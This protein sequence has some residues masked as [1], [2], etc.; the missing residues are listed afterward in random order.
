MPRVIASLDHPRDVGRGLRRPECV[1]CGRDGTLYVSDWR[2]GVTAIAADGGQ[3]TCLAIGAPELRPNGIAIDRD[4]S[5]LLADLGTRGGVW[6]LERDG[7]LSPFCTEVDG[8][9]VPPANFVTRDRAGRAWITVSTRRVP[10]ALGYRHDVADGFI[11]RVTDRGAAI[12]ADGLGYTNE[13]AVDPGGDWLYVNETFARRLSRF[14]IASGGD[15]GP[16]E[17]VAR[18]GPGTFPDGL[19]FDTEGGTWVVSIVSNRVIRIDASGNQQVVVE[20]ADPVWV[21]EVERAFE[22][23][24][25]GRPHLDRVESARLR[26][27]SSLA[28]GG[29]G[30]RTAFLGCLLGE[31]ITAF[32]STV[33]GAPPA[34]WEWT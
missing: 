23:G 17:T 31:S 11:I 22:G 14:R 13:A 7:R 27:I 32:R 1:L 15:L 19:A 24:T 16:R 3:R 33:A 6:R 29:R 20:D 34:H 28:F 4:G 9:A 30:L 21:D 25:L 26:N 2:G 8:Q 5:F 10:R 12:V 18:F